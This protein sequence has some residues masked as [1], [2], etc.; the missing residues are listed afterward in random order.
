MGQVL[1]GC[2]RTTEAVRREIQNSKESVKALSERL[3]LNYKTVLKWKNRDFVH[4]MPMGPKN[5]H[6]TVLTREEEAICIAFRKHSLLPLDDCLF[7]LREQIPH[8]SRS[9]LHR[10]F[11]RHGISKL[12]E[13]EEKKPKKK[14]K[15]YPIGYF[16]IDITEVRTEV[17]KLY[18]FVAIDRTSKLAYV[19]LVEKQGKIQAAQFLRNLIEKVP[20]K[21]H[22]ILTDNGVQFTNQARNHRALPHIFD[23][24]CKENGIEH[25]LTLPAH[26]WTN[27]QVERMNKTIKEA[28]VHRY[29]YDSQTSLQEHLQAFINAYNF[30][31]RL[32]SL[33]GLTPWEFIVKEWKSNPKSFKIKPNPYKP[34]LNI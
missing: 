2:A 9:S 28:T 18:L 3:G 10:L 4:D 23:R 11:Q 6:S 20:Y 22:T 32:K 7:A 17:S 15:K 5:P 29:Y 34:G 8:L 30:A 33:N 21:I 26:P 31:K 13:N 27:G 16:H 12:P 25:R 19:E 24:V 14:F 1:H